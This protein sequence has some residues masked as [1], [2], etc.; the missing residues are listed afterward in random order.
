M[1]Q[2][3]PS[4]LRVETYAMVWPSGETVGEEFTESFVSCCVP[5]PSTLTAQ[6]CCFPAVRAEWKITAWPSGVNAGWPSACG[7]FVMRVAPVPSAFVT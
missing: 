7:S 2:I 5:L 1:S 3:S 4:L 6:I